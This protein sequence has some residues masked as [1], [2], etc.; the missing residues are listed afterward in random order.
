[1]TMNIKFDN[2]RKYHRINF[3][4]KVDLDF[5]TTSHN[6]CQVK[7]LN[8]TGMFILGNFHHQKLKYCRIV[9]FHKEKSG[10]NC[11]RASGEIVWGNAE[12]I[13]H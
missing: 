3:D 1:M 2:R 12:G 11:L 10:N 8:L 7:N 6:G 9:L 5:I 13:G 4:R